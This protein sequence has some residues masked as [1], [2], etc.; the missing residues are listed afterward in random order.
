MAQLRQ[1]VDEKIKNGQA[2]VVVWDDIKH[3]PPS[4]L[5]ISPVAMIPH[6]SRKFRAILD[7]SF[8]VKLK[9][10]SVVPSVN[11]GTIKTAPRGAIDQIGHS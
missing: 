8:P 5:K 11:N 2:R 3:N 4:E 1:E 10:G 7:L 6:K 9:D